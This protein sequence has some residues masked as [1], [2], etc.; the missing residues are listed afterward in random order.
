MNKNV[1]PPDN[2][3]L[4]LPPH[5]A[6][7]VEVES[8]FCLLRLDIKKNIETVKELEMSELYSV[9]L[10]T[11]WKTFTRARKSAYFNWFNH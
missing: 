5:L 11:P 6:Q 10:D 7:F 3:N 8:E 2:L 1:L 9:V 4:C